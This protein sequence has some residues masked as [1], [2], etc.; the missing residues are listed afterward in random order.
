M[1]TPES[2]A[3]ATAAA[4][5]AVSQK[6]FTTTWL[7]SLLLG[8]LGIDR[9]YLG[10][11]GTGI[12]KLITG[13]GFGIWYLIDLIIVL[14][15]GTRDKQGAPLANQPEKKTKEWIITAAVFLVAIIIAA[16]SGANN[17]GRTSVS[18]DIEPPAVTSEETVEETTA[19]TVEP[20]PAEPAQPAET[21]GQKNAK[22]KA[23]Q[24]LDYQAFSR[25]GLIGQLEFEGFS[26]EDATYGTDAVGADWNEQAAK[27]AKQY[28]DYQA[29]S[30]QGLI[31]QLV[32]EGFSQAEA[33]YGASQNGY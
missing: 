26:V 30:R 5:P 27:K 33:E 25:S 9:F 11:I 4:Q 2:Q 23:K 19:P 17:A 28:L 12:L 8:S 7:L 13:G 1:T 16:V 24:Y 22:A 31:D 3:T 32:F 10:K 29:F 21:T 14:T 6:N 18:V 20:K 15:G